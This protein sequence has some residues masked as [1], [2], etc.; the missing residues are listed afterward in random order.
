MVVG[1]FYTVYT[2]FSDTPGGI[3]NWWLRPEKCSPDTPDQFF[4]SRR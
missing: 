2:V 1:F 4:T 3:R